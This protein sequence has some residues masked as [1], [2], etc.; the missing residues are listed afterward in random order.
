M[1][2]ENRYVET[3]S[4][5]DDDGMTR[6]E[7][8]PFADEHVP[9]AG[10]L[11]AARHRRHRADRP[12]LSG[13]FE[14]PAFAEK[15]VA[16]AGALADASGAVATRDGRVA[17]YLLGAPKPSA[18]WGPN[19]WVESAGQAL[20]DGIEA[21][22]VRDLYAGAAT[23][24]VD[25]GRTAHYV[26]VPASDAPLVDAWFRLGFGQQQAHAVRPPLPVYPRLPDELAVRRAERGDIPALAELEVSLPQHQGLAPCFSAGELGSVEESVAEWE[27][28][29]DDPDFTTFVAEHGGR[30]IGSAV[31]C[32]LTKSG[33]NNG[34]M[35]PDS[36]GFLGFAAVLPS[37]R[38]LGAGRALGE[39]VLAWAAE[40]GFDVVATDWRVTNLLSSRAWTALGFVPTFHR[41]HRSIGY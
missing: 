2:P 18:V 26:L 23:R 27:A 34:L 38:G 8:H 39:T 13:S 24:W 15:Q 37:A 19:L 6:L 3:G 12:E 22:V 33:S 31:G 40:A 28:D 11:L 5:P 32:A 30:V 21:E 36:A 16:E 14:D 7:I 29:F 4:M 20:G 17:G 25:E 9:E 1:T 35:R 10:R 41:L